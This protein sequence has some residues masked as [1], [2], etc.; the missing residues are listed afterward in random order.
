[1][2]ILFD[3]GAAWENAQESLG[4]AATFVRS[5]MYGDQ[6]KGDGIQK[7]TP[8]STAG[9]GIFFGCGQRA[10]GSGTVPLGPQGELKVVAVHPGAESTGVSYFSDQ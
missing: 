2:K 7:T 5:N 10:G 4:Q 3:M 8:K 6:P 1:M 9:V